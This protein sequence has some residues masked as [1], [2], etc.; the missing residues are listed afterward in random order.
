MEPESGAQNLCSSALSFTSV[1]NHSSILSLSRS[2]ISVALC[3]SRAVKGQD[4]VRQS[5]DIE[6]NLEI[7]GMILDSRAQRSKSKRKGQAVKE[8]GARNGL[9]KFLGKNEKQRH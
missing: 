4:W 3:G 2:G 7:G 9:M 6:G 1:V 8:G 5:R